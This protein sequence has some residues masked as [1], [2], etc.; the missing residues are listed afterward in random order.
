M[1]SE[2][3]TAPEV[4]AR[5]A[6]PTR[7]IMAPPSQAPGLT[8]WIVPRSETVSAKQIFTVGKWNSWGRRRLCGQLWGLRWNKVLSRYPILISETER[9]P[10]IASSHIL[11]QLDTSKYKNILVIMLTRYVYMVLGESLF[12]K[13][14]LHLMRCQK[15]WFGNHYPMRRKTSSKRG[16]KSVQW[17]KSRTGFEY[18]S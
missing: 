5:V 13:T 11:N 14:L 10:G 4:A 12:R 3:P 6:P 7:P 17:R 9:Y 15:T 18:W 2:V 1:G 16:R 8:S